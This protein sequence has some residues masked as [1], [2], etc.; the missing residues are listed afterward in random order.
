MRSDAA[1]EATAEELRALG[2]EPMLIRGNISSRARRRGGRR[3]RPARRARPQRGDR[4]DPSRARDRGQALG[5]DARRE[6]AR[7]ARPHPGSRAADAAGRLDRRHLEP[8]RASACSRTTRSWE[9]RRRRSRRSSA[10]SRSSSRRAASES[11][12]CP[13]AWSRPAPSTT[14]RTARRCSAQAKKTRPAGWSRPEDIA[15]AVTFL[16]SPEAEMIRGQTLIVDG[17]FSLRA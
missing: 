9:R 1:A 3:P 15:G 11:T 16:C 14:F 13:E 7:A 6:H 12:R 2:A 17:G 5:L 10:T 8:R 4:R